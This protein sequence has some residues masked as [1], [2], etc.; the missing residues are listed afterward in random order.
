MWP[1]PRSSRCS[2]PCD[3]GMGEGHMQRNPA[4]Y[5]LLTFVTLAQF[6]FVWGFLMARD[7]NRISR[8]GNQ[9]LR[10]HIA[11]FSVTYAI[12]WLGF[13]YVGPWSLETSEGFSHVEANN[14]W[15]MPLAIGMIAHFGWLLVFVAGRLR[16]L[17]GAEEPKAKTVILL[18]LLWALSLPYL[19]RHLNKAVEARTSNWHSRPGS[20]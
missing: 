2:R 4:L 1:W 14:I 16:I 11:V 3:S 15:M 13:L 7:V 18:S 6:A 12:Y 17:N 10:I 8:D 9:N 20:A 5:W 19:Q